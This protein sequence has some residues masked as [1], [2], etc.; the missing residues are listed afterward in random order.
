MPTKLVPFRKIQLVYYLHVYNLL[1]MFYV[2]RHQNRALM[3][4]N[5]SS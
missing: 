2:F 1:V 3:R 5:H 4:S